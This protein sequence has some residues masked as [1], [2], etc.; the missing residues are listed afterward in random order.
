MINLALNKETK[1]A[2][3]KN[4]DKQ[5][6]ELSKQELKELLLINAYKLALVR[7]QLEVVT[8]ILIKK[9]LATYEEIWQKTNNNFKESKL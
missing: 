7:S 9:K 5:I 8:D 3:E 2:V 1:Q 4:F 6:T